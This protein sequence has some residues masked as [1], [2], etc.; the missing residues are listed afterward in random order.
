VMREKAENNPESAGAGFRVGA[1][2]TTPLMGESKLNALSA[3]RTLRKRLS[4]S[5]SRRPWGPENALPGVTSVVHRASASFLKKSTLSC[6][7]RKRSMWPVFRLSNLNSRGST[8]PTVSMILPLTSSALSVDETV[9][10]R[11]CLK[12]LQARKAVETP[13]LQMG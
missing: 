5:S 1:A 9:D 4:V 6:S 11:S 10:D 8:T 12:S 7:L 2:V 13:G 3:R